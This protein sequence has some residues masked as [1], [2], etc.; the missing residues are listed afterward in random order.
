MYRAECD[1]SCTDKGKD[2]YEEALYTLK[3]GGYSVTVSLNGSTQQIAQ[4]ALDS[5]LSKF[6]T[7]SD[8]QGALT[9]VDNSTIAALHF[10]Y[11]S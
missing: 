7:D 10:R 11:V 8:M 5:E 6:S 9:V 1:I 2:I 4:E 3:T